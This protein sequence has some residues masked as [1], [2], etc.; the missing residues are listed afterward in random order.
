ML[1]IRQRLIGLYIIYGMYLNDK[2][3]TTPFYQLVLDRL[4]QNDPLHLAERRLLTDILKA[5]PRV[6]RRTPAE[7]I[8]EANSSPDLT[9]VELEPYRRAHAENM[10]KADAIH[11][12]SVAGV[13]GDL[14]PRAVELDGARSD[15]EKKLVVSTMKSLGRLCHPHWRAK[16]WSWESIYRRCCGPCPSATWGTTRRATS[17]IL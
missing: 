16:S 10:P 1:N 13:V 3:K 2:V 15:E 7:Y 5:V 11:A 9:P 4:G 17:S 14:E 8:R 12:C 6:A